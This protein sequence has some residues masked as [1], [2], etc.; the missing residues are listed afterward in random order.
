MEEKLDQIKKIQLITIL[1][2]GFVGVILSLKTTQIT[3]S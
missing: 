2:V 3:I 1:L